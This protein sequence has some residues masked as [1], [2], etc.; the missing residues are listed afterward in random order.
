[1]LQE[2]QAPTEWIK[3]P[4]HVGLYG[5]EM[6]DELADLG[7]QK[8]G[9]RMQGQEQ[10]TPKRQAEWAGDRGDQELGARGWHRR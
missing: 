4:S 6:A 9:V 1:M 8:H 7:V 3:V 2:R 5:N 10:T